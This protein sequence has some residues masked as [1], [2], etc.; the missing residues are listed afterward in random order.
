MDDKITIIEGPPP[1]FEAVSDGWV[2]GL[3]E[4]PEPHN[5][6]ITRLRTFNGQAL[7]ERCYR[8][9]RKGNGINLEYRDDTG[10]EAFAPIVAA[11]TV[12]TDEGQVL[13]LWVRLE[14]DESEYVMDD[15]AD[16]DFDPDDGDL[17]PETPDDWDD[18]TNRPL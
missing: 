7:L 13:L 2:L 16:D 17:G 9:W 1:T 14:A 6:A 12:D 8:A 11:R 3:N 15:D 18:L 10:L 4:S 5:L